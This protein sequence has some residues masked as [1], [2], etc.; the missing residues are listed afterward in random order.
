MG[1]HFVK[2]GCQQKN[3]GRFAN[4]L[5]RS[6]F[7]RE[8]GI[9]AN[10][11]LS[12]IFS[13]NVL[14][15]GEFANLPI[16]GRPRFGSVRLR[17]AHGTV[18][19]VLVFGSDGSSA[20]RVCSA[21]Q[22]SLRG[23]HISSSGFGSWRT[24][25]TVPFKVPENGSDGSGYSSVPVPSCHNNWKPNLPKRVPRQIPLFQFLRWSF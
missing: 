25:P 4:S 15:S 6:T 12:S 24:V 14:L 13:Y 18:R 9:L 22:H 1:T 21:F 8:I 19:A 7:P 10:S 5:E 23:W 16:T 17:F 2:F 3:I 11:V 20:E